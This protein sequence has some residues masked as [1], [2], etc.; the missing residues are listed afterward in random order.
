[1][2]AKASVP[3]LLAFWRLGVLAVNNWFLLEKA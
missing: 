3:I 2:V 1:M